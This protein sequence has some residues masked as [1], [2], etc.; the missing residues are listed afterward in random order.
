[1]KMSEGQ[2]VPGTFDVAYYLIHSM[3]ASTDSFDDMETRSAE[4]FLSLTQDCKLKQIIYL[5]GISN[6]T[7][8]SK[9]LSSR[10][11]VEAV[12]QGGTAALTVLRAGIIVGAGSA[13]FELIRDIVEKLPVMITPKWLKTRCQPIAIGNV[14]EFLVGVALQPQYYDQ[15]FDI[16][17]KEI[18]SYKEM[19][20]GFAK[21]RGLRRTIWT[22]PVMTPRLSS[23]WLYFVTSVSY[24]LAVNLVNSMKVDVI[25]KPNHLAEDLKIK[26]IPYPEAITL[27]LSLY[28]GDGLISSWKDAL[29]SSYAGSGLENFKGVPSFGILSDR[30]EQ[31]ITGHRQQVLANIWAIG[32][33]R[34]WYYGNWLWRIRGFVDKLMGGVGLRRGRTSDTQIEAGDALDFWRV[35][36]ADHANGRLLLFAEMKLPGEAWLE[37]QIL[38]T[39]NGEKLVQTAT[40]RPK[41]LLGRLYWYAVVPLH[42][43]VFNGMIRNIVAY[44]PAVANAPLVAAE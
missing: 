34:G 38:S 29:S 30:R 39:P 36:D 42:F 31:D 16:G 2:R 18:L 35:L 7:A 12:L 23:Y 15:S 14:L 17:G 11:H 22:V 8:L 21:V 10:L 6:D 5:S 4:N 3:A 25:C 41:G 40:F 37:F 20:L 13:S 27:A 19:L 9:H 1:V 24:P 43:F 33:Q 26:L 44:R 32:G 28:E